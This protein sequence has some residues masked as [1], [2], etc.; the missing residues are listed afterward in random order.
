MLGEKY[1]VQPN[2][3]LWLISTRFYNA[4]SAYIAIYRHNKRTLDAAAGGHDKGVSRIYPNTEIV[5]PDVIKMGE[6]WYRR[7]QAPMNIDVARKVASSN[8]IDLTSLTA[9]RAHMVPNFVKRVEAPKPPLGVQVPVPS[10]RMATREP[11]P[12]WFANPDSEVERC[13]KA[14]C[15]KFEQLCYFECLTVAKRL[16]D[17][18]KG[19][20]CEDLQE[21][22]RNT[23]MSLPL[24]VDDE[25][26]P[27]CQEL[28]Q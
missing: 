7:R 16:H 8:G 6:I 2:D 5:L 1:T 23:P 21:D 19:G 13:A 20:Y 3:T 25:T 18:D 12:E 4:P 10:A 22:P 28:V 17:G 24:E 27:Y 14:V 9:S 15:M 26:R 11:T